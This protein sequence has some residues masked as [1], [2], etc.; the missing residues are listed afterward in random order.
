MNIFKKE[1]KEELE[2]RDDPFYYY[3]QVAFISLVLGIL[4]IVPFM[5]RELFDTGSC[6]FLY[7]GDYNV[8]QVPFYRHCVEMVHQGNVGWDWNTDLGSNFIGSYSYYMLGSPF[9]WVM[10][11]FPSSWTPYLM[12]PMY[13]VKFV[14]AAL[15]SYAF[16]KRFVKNKNYAVIGAL[17][18]SFCG[19]QIYNVFFNQFQEVVALFPLLLIGMEEL[20]QNNR[21]GVFALAVAV[22]CM[23]NYFMFYGQVVF[24]LLY[25]FARCL[26][27][28]YRI[29]LKKLLLLAFE[30]VCGVM[31]GAVLFLPACLGVLGNYR[32]SYEFKD[33]KSMLIYLKGNKT[34]I[35]RYGHILQS[36]FFPPDIPSRVNFFYGHTA[37]WSSNAAWLPVFGLSG[38][39]AY[40]KARKHS[41]LGWLIVVLMGFS[42]VPILNSSFYNFNSNYYARWIYML[43]LVAVIATIIA[44]DDDRIKWNFGIVANTAACVAIAT[45]SGLRWYKWSSEDRSQLTYSLGG[46]PFTARLWIS[47]SIALVCMAGLF[48]VIKRY[49]KTRYFD[50]IILGF[51]CTTIVVYGVVH[52]YCGSEHSDNRARLIKESIAGD[53][54]IDDDDFYRID[55]FRLDK[56]SAT[57]LMKNGDKTEAKLSYTSVFDNLGISWEIPSVE[58]FH[59]VV[60]PSV[61]DF[62]ETMG[63]T[64]NVASRADYA[65]Y[66]LLGFL[67]VKYSFIRSASAYKHVTSAEDPYFGDKNYTYTYDGLSFDYFDTQTNYDIFINN[68]YIKPGFYYEYFMTESQFEKVG[69]SLRHTLLC[70]YLVIPDA[71]RDYYA[72]F[73]TEAI[74]SGTPETDQVKCE[75]ANNETY[76]DSVTERRLN[77]CDTFEYDGYSF[78]AEITMEKDNVVM[79]TVPYE[80]GEWIAKGG[81]TAT[82]NGKEVNV[83]KVTYGFVAVECSGAEDG[84]YVIKFSYETPGLKLG[85]ILT[86]S[87]IIIF[88]LYM[89]VANKKKFVPNYKFFKE[90]YVEVECPRYEKNYTPAEDKAEEEYKPLF[91]VN[92]VNSVNSVNEIKAEEEQGKE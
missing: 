37:R 61:M 63:V 57:K 31:L 83:R 17:L 39:I 35:E 75:L 50:N 5:L 11:L 29:T 44:L 16:F 78:T 24:C 91:D 41:T 53:V 9:F 67:S 10:C 71:E 14:A 56:G 45:Y 19:F 42:L 70:K 34:Y 87:G 4:V 84:H 79:F 7:Y 51:V 54:V 21:K 26:Q 1:R 90:D 18:Y 66:G 69:K 74:K 68:Y 82:V 6:I 3:K 76:I 80:V 12:G 55:F 36:F 92:S 30:A 2:L 88:I 32:L 86:G 64:R 48:F 65:K 47:V 85:A 33:T 73:M 28:S 46:E 15:I 89:V 27:K 77:T 22:N 38:A 72:Q 81:W 13:V 43:V 52:I 58:C 62:Y 25:F 49:R 40:I 8:Q 60:P 23:C 59:S 20:V